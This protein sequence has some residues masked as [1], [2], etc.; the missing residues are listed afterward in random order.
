MS[1]DYVQHFNDLSATLLTRPE[2]E[3]LSRS[4]RQYR[5]GQDT[6]LLVDTVRR[7]LNTS[8]RAKLLTYIR[9]PMSK[10]ERTRFDKMLSSPSTSSQIG[11]ISERS[12]G[13]GFSG[14][15]FPTQRED[16]LG[17]SAEILNPPDLIK[18]TWK[19][20]FAKKT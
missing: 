7:I 20:G 2:R 17:K 1:R 4:L 19:V 3:E 16:I 18:I 9:A 6:A 11:S 8:D 14:R 13:S 10:S 15:S 5:R 12:R